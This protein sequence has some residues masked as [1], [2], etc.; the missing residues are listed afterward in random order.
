MSHSHSS[1]WYKKMDKMKCCIKHIKGSYILWDTKDQ[2]PLI[3]IELLL[4]ETLRALSLHTR[5]YTKCIQKCLSL[6]NSLIKIWNPYNVFLPPFY[7]GRRRETNKR[8][9]WEQLIV[10]LKQNGGNIRAHI[11]EWLGNIICTWQSAC[12]NKCTG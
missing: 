3:Q 9:R 8:S 11:A 4:T 2:N 12:R 5:A 6:H 1:T 10:S 7:R